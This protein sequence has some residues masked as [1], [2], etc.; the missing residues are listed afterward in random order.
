MQAKVFSPATDQSQSPPLVHLES[1]VADDLVSV[2]IPTYNRAK[3]ILRTVESALQQTHRN[4][5]IIVV[6]D[7]STDETPEVLRPLAGR[8]QFLRQANAG[9]SAARNAGIALARGSILAFLD[10]DDVWLP[11]K[12]ERQVQ[13]LAWAGQ[14]TPCCICNSTMTDGAGYSVTSFEVSDIKGTGDLGLWHNPAQV[15]ATRFLLFNQVV[16]VR[17]EA[18]EKIGGFRADLRLLEDYDLAL[19]LARLGPWGFIREPLVIKHD[20]GADRLSTQA[21]QQPLTIY[22]AQEKVLQ[23][24]LDQNQLADPKLK[25]AWGQALR[26]VK[27]RI[28]ANKLKARPSFLVS[29]LG[30]LWLFL[31]R[32]QVG[33]WRRTPWWPQPKLSLYEK[34]APASGPQTQTDLRPR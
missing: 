3:S 10:S 4:L 32:L 24:L 26:R 5:E 6:D 14:A 27:A 16:A 9:P 7:G 8:I 15:L 19:R 29:A 17:R 22:Y 33:T 23:S 13:L 1:R 11:Q 30:R 12:I 31:L 28:A 20:D 2:I 21:E 18:L 25:A 34:S